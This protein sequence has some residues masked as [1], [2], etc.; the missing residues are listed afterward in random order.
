MD[1]VVFV[2]TALRKIIEAKRDDNA[3]DPM[4]N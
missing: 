1:R 4:T 3:S 2:M